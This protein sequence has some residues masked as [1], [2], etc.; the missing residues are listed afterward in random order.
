MPP[1]KAAP[2]SAAASGLG[3]TIGKHPREKLWRWRVSNDAPR[4]SYNSVPRSTMLAIV[5]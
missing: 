4:D 3:R 2:L 1:T 5:K